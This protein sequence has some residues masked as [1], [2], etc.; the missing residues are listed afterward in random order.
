M[1]NRYIV[2]EPL[3]EL[4]ELSETVT[5]KICYEGKRLA[6]FLIVVLY[7]EFHNFDLFAAYT[8]AGR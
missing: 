7:L 4:V 6:S 5:R 3:P 8:G 2:L 1:N